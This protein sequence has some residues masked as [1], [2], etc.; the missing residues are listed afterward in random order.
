MNQNKFR[1]ILIAAIQH[2]STQYIYI[3]IYIYI[4]RERERERE[5]ECVYV[6]V[7]VGCIYV[8]VCRYFIEFTCMYLCRYIMWLTQSDIVYFMT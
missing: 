5:R 7:R 6:Y 1:L 8:C 4:E 2:D 3:Y